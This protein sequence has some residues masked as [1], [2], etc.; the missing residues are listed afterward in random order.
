MRAMLSAAIGV[1]LLLPALCGCGSRDEHPLTTQPPPASPP[2][3]EIAHSKITMI[4]PDSR[5]RFEATAQDIE[6]VSLDGPYDLEAA[7][8]RYEPVGEPPVLMSADRARLD[9]DLAR[10][11]MEGNVRINSDTW[12]VEGERIEYDLNTRQVVG[13]SRTK[14]TLLRDGATGGS[15]GPS[16]EGDMP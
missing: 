3:H 7:E 15:P 5:W 10:L 11:T 13:D 14:F 8:C 12:Q 6:A 9:E 4:D 16:V 1:A 2:S